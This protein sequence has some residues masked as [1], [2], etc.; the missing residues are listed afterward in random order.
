MT[1]K[2]IH[3]N[4][5]TTCLTATFKLNHLTVSFVYVLSKFLSFMLKEINKQGIRNVSVSSVQKNELL[6]Q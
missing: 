6:R 4:T 2:E 3:V 5:N 1:L